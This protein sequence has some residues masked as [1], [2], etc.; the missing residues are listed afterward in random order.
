MIRFFFA[1][2]PSTEAILTKNINPICASMTDGE[3]Y[4]VAMSGVL[5]HNDCS[6]IND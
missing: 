6:G 1:V 3:E 5:L 2:W 4:G